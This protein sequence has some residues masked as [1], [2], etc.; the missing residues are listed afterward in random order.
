MKKIIITTLSIVGLIG[1]FTACDK[2]KHS[3]DDSDRE[4]ITQI[5]TDA[6]KMFNDTNDYK[7]FTDKFLAENAIVLM[8]NNEPVL[9]RE[10]VTKAY[11]AIFGSLGKIKYDVTITEINGDGDSAY[12]YGKYYFEVLSNGEKDHGKYIVVWKRMT[13]GKWKVIYDISNTSV[14]I[15]ADSVKG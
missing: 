8:A 7:A 6:F 11:I 10:A 2:P 12:M 4:A 1:A 9:G 5:T 14:P 15:K 13:D 3:F